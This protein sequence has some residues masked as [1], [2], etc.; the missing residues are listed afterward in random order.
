L[1]RF[2]V[3]SAGLR[4]NSRVNGPE[5]LCL[6]YIFLTILFFEAE[7]IGGV[8]RKKVK[9]DTRFGSTSI[10]SFMSL[11]KALIVLESLITKD[12]VKQ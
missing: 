7:V 3:G 10:C 2:C 1:I 5:C 4:G 9:I 6:A 8:L 11:C 12:Q